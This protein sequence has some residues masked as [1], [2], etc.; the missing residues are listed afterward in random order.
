MFVCIDTKT[1]QLVFK[2][3]LETFLVLSWAL[4]R[5]SWQNK[6]ALQNSPGI[7][8]ETSGRSFQ[9]W[10]LGLPTSP[11]SAFAEII[12]NS[13]VRK[14]SCWGLLRFVANLAPQPIKT[15]QCLSIFGISF[16]LVA[17]VLPNMKW[18]LKKKIEY[19]VDLSWYWF[20]S[21]PTCLSSA[22][23]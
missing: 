15:F 21:R 20:C 5:Q 2:F 22:S 13:W 11:W 14:N 10:F 17:K 7:C 6:P 16:F 1:L 4:D 23:A 8:H 9:C 12:A 19:P 18:L 3:E